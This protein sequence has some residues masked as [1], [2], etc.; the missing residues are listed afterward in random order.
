METPT[1]IAIF[2]WASNIGRGYQSSDKFRNEDDEKGRHEDLM[3]LDYEDTTT[4]PLVT[5]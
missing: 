3:S 5:I 1:V 4:H 2:N